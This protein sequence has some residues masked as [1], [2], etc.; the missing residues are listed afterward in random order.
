MTKLRTIDLPHVKKNRLALRTINQKTAPRF[1]SVS[2]RPKGNRYYMNR[3]FYTEDD[4]LFL[5]FQSTNGNN[6]ALY[7]QKSFACAENLWYFSADGNTHGQ[8]VL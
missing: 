7:R 4:M 6:V 2:F 8:H 3:I 5:N 1:L